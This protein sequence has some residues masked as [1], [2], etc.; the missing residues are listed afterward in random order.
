MKLA[1]IAL[2]AILAI[3]LS[4]PPETSPPQL[5]TI[6]I[7]GF[8]YVPDSLVASAGDTI[9]FVNQDLVIHTVTADTARWDSGDLKPRASYLLVVHSR[10]RLSFHCELHPAMKGHVTIR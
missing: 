10:G 6:S 5:R 2:A 4:S 7:K 3:G 9:A 8:A 1:P